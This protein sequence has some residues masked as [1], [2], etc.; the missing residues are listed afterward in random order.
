M[1]YPEFVE[2]I[3]IGW[4]HI[5]SGDRVDK[6][7]VVFTEHKPRSQINCSDKSHSLSVVVIN[8]FKVEKILSKEI[9]LVFY[10]ITNRKIARK[11][12]V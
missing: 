6:A 1:V 2:V 9:K 10:R 3:A 12:D 7:I 11:F 4:V 5:V 8:Y